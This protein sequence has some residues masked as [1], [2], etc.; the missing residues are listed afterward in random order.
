MYIY[1]YNLRFAINLPWEGAS[2]PTK[3]LGWH[4][5]S[6]LYQWLDGSHGRKPAVGT[7]QWFEHLGLGK[8]RGVQ[9]RSVAEWG[10]GQM[11]GPKPGMCFFLKAS[12]HPK[13]WRKSTWNLAF[14]SLEVDQGHI[15]HILVDDTSQFRRISLCAVEK[16]LQSCQAPFYSL[17][18]IAR[19]GKP[20]QWHVM[21]QW[22]DSFYAVV[23]YGNLT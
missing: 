17:K 4:A 8:K 3:H 7:A 14:F 9:L 6:M 16:D 10:G 15:L 11:A 19:E 23:P 18:V 12:V 13:K 21:E 5:F 1:I 22:N 2:I 20:H